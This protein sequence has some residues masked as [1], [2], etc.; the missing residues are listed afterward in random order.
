MKAIEVVYACGHRDVQ[1]THK[2]TFQT[3]KEHILT[4]RGDCV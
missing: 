1:S 2:T 4:R 3:T